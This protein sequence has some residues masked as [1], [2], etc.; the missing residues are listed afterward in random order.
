MK[1]PA[2][3]EHGKGPLRVSAGDAGLTELRQGWKSVRGETPVPRWLDA[4][5]DS[6]A[7]RSGETPRPTETWQNQ[8]HRTR[9]P[10]TQRRLHQ[11]IKPR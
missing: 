11:Q 7:P 1:K 4:Q 10:D 3:P 5:R 6:P 2:S 9:H 8:R